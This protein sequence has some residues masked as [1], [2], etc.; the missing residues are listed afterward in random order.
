MG[1]L[2]T[3]IRDGMDRRRYELATLAAAKRARSSYCSLAHGKVLAER[4]YGPDQVRAIYTDRAGVDEV[5]VAVM[6]LAEKVAADA[7]SVGKED[8]DRLLDLGLT[9]RDVLDVVLAAAAR[10]FFTRMLDGLGVLPD[11]SYRQLGE[12]LVGA[13]TVGRP[14]EGPAPL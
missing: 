9:E 1:A 11:G 4:F 13:L 10:S 14:I 5:D 8:I 6:D 3:A 2:I 7:T 12:D